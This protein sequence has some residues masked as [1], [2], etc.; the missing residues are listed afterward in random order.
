MPKP[1]YSI[2][3][4]EALLEALKPLEIG[5]IES[6]S[7]VLSSTQLRY[8]HVEKYCFFNSKAYTRNQIIRTDFYELL[9]LCWD[10]GQASP[11]HN[12]EGQNC[13]MYV[14]DGTLGETIYT[15]VSEEEERVHL[16]LSSQS[17]SNPGG[18]FFIRDEVG[19]HR[20]ANVGETRAVSLHLYSLPFDTCNIYCE[21]TGKVQPKILQYYSKNGELIAPRLST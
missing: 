5:D 12:H 6:F 13:W 19:L 20:V 11:I 1:K 17:Q 7:A 14:V 3:S 18:F 15:I 2:H 10:V 4:I 8:E 9:V 21:E 16:K